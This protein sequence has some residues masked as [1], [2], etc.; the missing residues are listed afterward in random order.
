MGELFAVRA[1]AKGMIG[2]GSALA[3]RDPEAPPI[4]ARGR[5]HVGPIRAVVQSADHVGHLRQSGMGDPH[6][7]GRAS[8]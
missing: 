1:R 5:W 2:G 6:Q 4:D 8:P 3:G 7:C